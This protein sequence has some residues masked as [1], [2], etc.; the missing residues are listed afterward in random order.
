MR[1]NSQSE[2]QLPSVSLPSVVMGSA[3]G[4]YDVH[5]TLVTS[6]TVYFIV[7]KPI[8]TS[9]SLKGL[10][11]GDVGLPDVIEEKSSKSV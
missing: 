11:I 10:S 9:V 2:P 8:G 5:E 6:K 7:E 4:A 1:L 3:S